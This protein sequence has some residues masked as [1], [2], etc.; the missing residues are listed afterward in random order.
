MRSGAITRICADWPTPVLSMSASVGPSQSSE[1]SPE[2]FRNGRI[3]KDNSG[4]FTL[5]APVVEDPERTNPVL[6]THPPASI[7]RTRAPIPIHFHGRAGLGA[8]IGTAAMEASV[9][10]APW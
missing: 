8:A 3:A 4:A 6:R 1:L 10:R 5:P 2:A 9:G 7:T